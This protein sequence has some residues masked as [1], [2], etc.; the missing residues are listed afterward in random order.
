MENKLKKAK[1]MGANMI[2]SGIFGFIAIA[3]VGWG[4]YQYLDTIYAKKSLVER[5][6]TSVKIV[7]TKVDYALDKQLESL[8]AQ[9]DKLNAKADSGKATQAD[10]EQLRY[11]RDEIKRLREIRQV[12]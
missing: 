11:L 5:N 6:T 3:G 9:A 10:F 8:L 7:A 1:P 12:Q 2:T 4:S